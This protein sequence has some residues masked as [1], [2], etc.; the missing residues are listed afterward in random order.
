[1]SNRDKNL[2]YAWMPLPPPTP[3]QVARAARLQAAGHAT[4]ADDLLDLLTVLGL[5]PNPQ[6]GQGA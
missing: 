3:D 4:G 2:P 1:M 5:C 6:L